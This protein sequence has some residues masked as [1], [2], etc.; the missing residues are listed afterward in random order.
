MQKQSQS[1]M[2]ENYLDL[3]YSR[4][5]YLFNGQKPLCQ[6]NLGTMAGM[7]QANGCN[8]IMAIATYNGYNQE[9]SLVFNEASIQRGLFRMMDRKTYHYS[10]SDVVGYGNDNSLRRHNQDK[11]SQIDDDGLPTP[12]KCIGPKDIILAKKELIDP[13]LQIGGMQSVMASNLVPQGPQYK[14]SSVRARDKHG[15]VDR[16]IVGVGK[17]RRKSTNGSKSAKVTIVTSKM[18]SVEV[19]DKFVSRLPET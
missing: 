12:G 4:A 18:R 3:N 10:G 8:V 16:V 7:P 13:E 11:F 19:G 17:R 1:E 6:T 2:P 15:I 14:D 5:H 9:D